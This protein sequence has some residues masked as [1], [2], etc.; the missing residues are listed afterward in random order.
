MIGVALPL[1]PLDL[2]NR[3]SGMPIPL[4]PSEAE[5]LST[6]PQVAPESV[7]FHRP[8]LR[9]P[10]YRM[11]GRLGSTA[12]RSPFDRPFSLPP[13]FIGISITFQVLPRSFERRSAPLPTHDPVYVPAARYTVLG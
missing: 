4:S 12:S 7:V 6:L 8:F 2:S 10:K 1:V 13:I 9:D 11:L 5:K 3:T